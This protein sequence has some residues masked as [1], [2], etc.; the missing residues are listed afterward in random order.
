VQ[1]A[2]AAILTVTGVGVV[3]AAAAGAAI[4]NGLS[5][6]NLGT[7]LRAGAIAGATAFAF[8]IVGSATNAV[9]GYDPSGPHIAPQFGTPEYV[10]NVAGHAGVGCLTSIA[11]GGSCQ[12]G[13]LS[14]AASAAASPLVDTG[15]LV[16]GT[17]VSGVVGGLAS[18]AGGGKFENGAVTA[19]FGYLFNACGGPNGCLKL[20]AA[21]GTA[22]G[23]ASAVGC[24]LGTAS[25]CVVGNP[26]I[27]AA[28]T[29]FGMAMGAVGDSLGD[30]LDRLVHGNSFLS[31][32]QT[33]VYELREV[34]TRELLKY[35]ITSDPGDRYTSSFYAS[36]NSTMNIIQTYNSRLPARMHEFGL[37]LGYSAANGRLPPLSAR[38]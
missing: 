30:S 12:S 23:V 14:G 29:G 10:F 18:V 11:S 3:V 17:A 26:A 21:A 22:A 6:G 31:M 35:G 24:D 38:C 15:D 33:Y 13:A 5:G 36:T 28:G 25:A 8:N 37:C 1:I 32:R 16:G 7:M 34:E 2:V 27:V 19:A 9:A 4:V 20:G